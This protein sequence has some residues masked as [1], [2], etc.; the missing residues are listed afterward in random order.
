MVAA[1]QSPLQA[2][3]QAIAGAAGDPRGNEDKSNESIN[4]GPADIAAEIT[5]VSSGGKKKDFTC[6]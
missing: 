4:K 2:S 3:A 6:V 5:I 1:R